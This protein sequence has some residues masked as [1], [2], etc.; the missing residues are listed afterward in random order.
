MPR[1]YRY[2]RPAY[3]SLAV[4]RSGGGCRWGLDDSGPMTRPEPRLITAKEAAA[5]FSLP[6]KTF[7][8]LRLGRVCFGARVL[9]DRYAL[10][11]HL[12]EISGLSKPSRLAVI[13]ANDAE[14]ALDRFNHGLRHAAGRS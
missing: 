2:V 11:A 4:A 14:A 8:R 12:D 1:P 10:D 13:E 3:L 7:E 9:Y 6:V 5:Y